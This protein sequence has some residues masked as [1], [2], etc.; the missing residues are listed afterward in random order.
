MQMTTPSS[1]Y[2]LPGPIPSLNA[3]STLMK[4]TLLPPPPP[5]PPSSAAIHA[6]HHHAAQHPLHRSPAT[7]QSHPAYSR[8][9]SNG[10][11]F[12][13]LTIAST[14]NGT[15]LLTT[16]HN[17]NNN[18]NTSTVLTSNIND[19]NS[20]GNSST[21]GGSSGHSLSQS[22]ES[23]NNIGLTDDEVRTMKT[24]GN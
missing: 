11:T 10:D 8:I 6:I 7:L 24:K 16:N 12:Q 20:G 15:S 17:N 9:T 23:I 21:S 5:L 13:P 1:A 2:I 4:Q 22:M 19:D 14:N 3:K 18:N